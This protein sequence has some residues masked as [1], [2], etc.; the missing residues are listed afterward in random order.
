VYDPFISDVDELQLDFDLAADTGPMTGRIFD[1][2]ILYPFKFRHPYLGRRGI[3]EEVQRL[4]QIGYDRST[5]GV[6]LP[7]FDRYG[8]LINIK[9]RSVTDKKFWYLDGGDPI[10]RHVYGL[11]LIISRGIKRV[12]VTES[13]TDALYLWT[14]GLPAVALGGAHLS[15][16]QRTLLLG[17]G[18][19][20]LLIATDNDPAGDR[21][22]RILMNELSGYLIAERIQLPDGVK[23]VNEIPADQLVEAMKISDFLSFV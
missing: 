15:K 14:N 5:K 23:D 20:E 11:D 1:E 18:I 10:G 19:E 22:A 9:F 6:S 12:F 8:R 13:E 16:R 17:S 3:S 21:A 4:F 2:S 7:W